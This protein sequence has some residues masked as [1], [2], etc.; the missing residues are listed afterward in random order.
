MAAETMLHQY[1]THFSF[2]EIQAGFVVGNNRHRTRKYE[3]SGHHECIHQGTSAHRAVS[4]TRPWRGEFWQEPTLLVYQRWRRSP[5]GIARKYR[6]MSRSWL[7]GR[8]V[9]A[10]VIPRSFRLAGL[11]AAA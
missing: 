1:R 2:K 11:S 4:E 3:D 9:F 5:A 7:W 8:A 10:S 6:L